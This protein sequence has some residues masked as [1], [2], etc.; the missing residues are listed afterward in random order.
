MRGYSSVVEDWWLQ[1]GETK[2]TS[3][4]KQKG[5]YRP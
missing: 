5:L 4:R 2:L 3:E 1:E